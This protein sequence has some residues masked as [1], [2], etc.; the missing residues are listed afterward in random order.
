[1][2]EYIIKIGPIRNLRPSASRYF[3]LG[4]EPLCQCGHTE[5]EHRLDKTCGK[6]LCTKWEHQR[7]EN[8]DPS[9]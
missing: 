4:P 8:D 2:P 7:K 6:C 5:L 3:E 9:N 1:M